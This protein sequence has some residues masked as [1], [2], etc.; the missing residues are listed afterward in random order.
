MHLI[1]ILLYYYTISS[2]N[3]IIILWPLG[4]ILDNNINTI[5]NQSTN[6]QH[7]KQ[8]NYNRSPK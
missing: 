5:P 4:D 3:D 8:Y 1:I 7:F 2:Y 6:K